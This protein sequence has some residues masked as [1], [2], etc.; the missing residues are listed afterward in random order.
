MKRFLA[1][2]GL[3]VALL[4]TAA[5]GTTSWPSDPAGPVVTGSQTVLDE[6]ALASAELA[7]NTA[8]KAYISIDTRGLWPAGVKEKVKPIMMDARVALTLAEQAYDAGNASTFAAQA[9]LV[10]KLAGDALALIPKK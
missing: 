6:K 9:A 2:A 10:T 4:S 8:A 5:C 1:A 7:Y 3:A